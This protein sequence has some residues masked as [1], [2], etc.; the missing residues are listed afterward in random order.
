MTTRMTMR[1]M[2]S[3]RRVLDQRSALR[4]PSLDPEIKRTEKIKM[5]KGYPRTK[6]MWTRT[7]LST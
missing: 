2:N 3:L 5:V 6:R 1:T 4:V 7:K